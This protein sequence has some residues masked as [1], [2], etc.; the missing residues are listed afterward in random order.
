ML[1]KERAVKDRHCRQCREKI[2]AGSI[3]YRT[4]SS[5]FYSHTICEACIKAEVGRKVKEDDN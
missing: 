4:T 1:I 2:K 3:C 5:G